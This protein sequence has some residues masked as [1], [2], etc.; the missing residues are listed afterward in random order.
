MLQLR[1]C[2]VCDKWNVDATGTQTATDC[3]FIDYLH[4]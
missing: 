1:F 2:V 3:V 4:I